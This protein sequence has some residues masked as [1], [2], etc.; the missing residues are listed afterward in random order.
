M[1]IKRTLIVALSAVSLSGCVTTGQLFGSDTSIVQA[2]LLVQAVREAN[3]DLG[4]FNT[5]L[6]AYAAIDCL[7]L[8]DVARREDCVVRAVTG[9]RHE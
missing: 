1:S 2:A 3:P 4:D 9:L 7:R 8:A 5:R 6:A